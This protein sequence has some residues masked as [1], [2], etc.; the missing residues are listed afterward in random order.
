MCLPHGL[1]QHGSFECTMTL[2]PYSSTWLV[3]G[4]NPPEPITTMCSYVLPSRDRSRESRTGA[5]SKA[6][7]PS[8]RVLRPGLEGIPCPRH[9]SEAQQRG[10][11]SR[12][13]CR[14]KPDSD[15]CT[16]TRTA[17]PFV[18]EHVEESG[19]LFRLPSSA[20]SRRRPKDDFLRG[21]RANNARSDEFLPSWL[22]SPACHDSRPPQQVQ[23]LS[24][25]RASGGLDKAKR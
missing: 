11:K 23:H 13:L 17:S 20:C 7:K 14:I 18:R 15:R 8:P 9:G 22:T 24:R 21:R 1:E 3:R 2:D 16:D 10:G 12:L 4:I 25:R 5:L 6:V 19:W